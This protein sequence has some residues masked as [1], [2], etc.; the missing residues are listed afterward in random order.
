MMLAHTGVDHAAMGLLAAVAVAMYGAMWLRQPAPSTKRLVAWIGGVA[1]VLGAS[2]PWVETR[3]EE[4]FSGHMLQHLA[5]I[6]AAAP[7]LVLAEP[8]RTATRAGVVP[9]TAAGRRL[10]AFWRR[11]AP[12]VGPLAFIVVLFTTHLTAIYDRALNDR[13]LHELE[14]GGYLLG[15][16]ATWAAVLG[17]GRAGAVAR[18]GAAFGVAAAGAVLGMVLLTAPDPLIPTYEARLGTA[19]ALTD[20]HNAAAMMWIGGMGTTVPLLLL[21]VWRW[22]SAEERITRQAEAITDRAPTPRS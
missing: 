21:A 8:L 15:A 4:S 22:A 5:V 3:A 1:I 13:W 7:L 11:R 6:V 16:V 18:V 17:V 12:V 14:H 10:G 20:Q 9:T 19:D 2:S